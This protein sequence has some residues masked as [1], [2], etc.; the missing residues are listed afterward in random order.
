MPMEASI[1]TAQALTWGSPEDSSDPRV[2][3][4][5][6]NAILDSS[7][8]P[9]LSLEHG[10]GSVQHSLPTVSSTACTHVVRDVKICPCS[11]F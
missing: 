10:V 4:S 5:S 1:C 6:V 8:A 9:E 2:S 11:V 7:S 3:S